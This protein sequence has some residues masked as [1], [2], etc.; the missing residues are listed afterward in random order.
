VLYATDVDPGALHV[1]KTGV[2]GLDRVSDFSRNYQGA[3]GRGSLADYYTVAYGAMAFDRMLRQRVVF[4]DH[5]LATDS[6]F[7]EVPLVSCRNVLIYFEQELQNRALGLYAESLVRKGFL[8]LGAHETVRFSRHE[9]AFSEHVPEH[10]IYR[11]E[12]DA[13]ASRP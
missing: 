5:S 12:D 9:P 7:A 4:S 10:R 3:G 11:R 2:Y 6:V 8:G 1:A 13:S